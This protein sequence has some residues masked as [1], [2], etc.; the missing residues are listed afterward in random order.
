[1]TFSPMKPVTAYVLFDQTFGR[2]ARFLGDSS[3]VQWVEEFS[4]K[5]TRFNSA[6]EARNEAAYFSRRMDSS[7]IVVLEL[8]ATYTFKEVKI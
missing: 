5:I 8:Q 3:I 4:D 7:Q 6:L 2:F 1:M